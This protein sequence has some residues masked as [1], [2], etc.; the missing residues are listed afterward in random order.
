MYRDYAREVIKIKQAYLFGPQKNTLQEEIL[1][2]PNARIILFGAGLGGHAAAKWIQKEGGCV[3]C[4]CDSM[5]SGKDEK[6]DI[7]IISPEELKKYY[8]D[9]QTYI[10]IS[11][12]DR[13]RDEIASL[14]LELG[15]PIRK[16]IPSY[17]MKDKLT[18]DELEA[19][20]DGY[21]WMFDH[22]EDDTSRDIIINRIKNY[23]FYFEAPHD[24]D[25]KRY[26]DSAIMP[27]R[28]D[29]IYLDGGAFNGDS[30]LSFLNATKNQYRYIWG[31]EPDLENYRN[32]INTLH[33]YKN[34]TLINQGIWSGEETLPCIGGQE[35]LSCFDK[36]GSSTVSVIGLDHFFL[37]RNNRPTVIKLDIQGAELYA[38]QGAR[39][40]IKEN[41]PKLILCAYHEVSHLYELAQ[42]VFRI[43]PSYKFWIRHYSD[44][45]HETILYAL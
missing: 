6:F 10:V 41:H 43:D 30:I 13:Y 38:L 22:V 45:L 14:L 34:V 20:L 4:F 27:L 5:K 11:V 16:I 28:T 31:F 17:F 26:F 42:T 25:Y 2:S 23:L 35:T 15:C 9:D 44:N 1:S 36:A 19:H 24:E 29:E 12:G 33:D 7:P 8:G 21:Q 37:N 32:A 40:L 3:F 18:L 39:K